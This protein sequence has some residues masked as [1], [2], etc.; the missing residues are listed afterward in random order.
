MPNMAILPCPYN[1]F[2]QLKERADGIS[3]YTRDPIQEEE[4]Y[5]K[6]GKKRDRG[7][8]ET[9]QN[10]RSTRKSPRNLAKD[11]FSQ[12]NSAHLKLD[13][14]KHRDNLCSY[15]KAQ[16]FGP[17]STN[18]LYRAHWSKAPCILGQTRK[19]G[20]YSFLTGHLVS[21]SLRQNHVVISFNLYQYFF[22]FEKLLKK[23]RCSFK[24]LLEVRQTQ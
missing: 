18:S 10:T 11:Q 3:T 7:G 4:I 9:P 15:N 19:I 14:V 12:M 17:L 6:K 21:F 23:K 20:P 24:K 16:L 13:R 8:G 22:F 1:H 2:Q 5:Y